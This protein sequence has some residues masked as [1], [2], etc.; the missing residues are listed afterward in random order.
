MFCFIYVM[1]NIILKTKAFKFDLCTVFYFKK[2]KTTSSI[3]YNIELSSI[4]IS[5]KYNKFYLQ[6]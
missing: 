4:R 2:G 6:S 3:D 5:D 1:R